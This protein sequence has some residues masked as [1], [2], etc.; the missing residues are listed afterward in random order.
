MAEQEG[1][2][3]KKTRIWFI[4][5]TLLEEQIGLSGLLTRKDIPLVYGDRRYQRSGELSEKIL[6]DKYN[7][8]RGNKSFNQ[9]NESL[10]KEDIQGF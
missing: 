9:W 2:I 5:D 6:P 7:G 1:K 10:K 8:E 4:G 3:D